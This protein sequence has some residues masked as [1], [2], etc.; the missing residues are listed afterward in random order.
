METPPRWC[1]L[2]GWSREMSQPK[3]QRWE[4]GPQNR[5]GRKGSSGHPAKVSM[6]ESSLPLPSG[7]RE[8]SVAIVTFAK[9][10]PYSEHL[11]SNWNQPKCVAVGEGAS[12]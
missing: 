10:S 1:V 6:K 9:K 4:R 11:A 12:Q 2:L 3:G 7:H 8:S 5:R